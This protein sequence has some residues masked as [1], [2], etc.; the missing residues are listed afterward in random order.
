[1]SGADPAA[2]GIA[3]QRLAAQQIA[4][5]PFARPAELVEWMGAIQA[6]EPLAAWWALGLRLGGSRGTAGNAP[7]I[8]AAIAGALTDGSVLCTHV[9]RWTWQLVTPAD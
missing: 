8:S 3:A 9:M 5:S 1:M 4:R 6:Q 2:A 7:A